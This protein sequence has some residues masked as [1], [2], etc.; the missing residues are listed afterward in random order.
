[1]HVES[2][3]RD[4]LK[5]KSLRLNRWKT[6]NLIRQIRANE[7]VE[8]LKRINSRMAIIALSVAVLAFSFATQV[9]QCRAYSETRSYTVDQTKVSGLYGLVVGFLGGLTGLSSLW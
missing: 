4:G 6:L 8:A 5:R 9:V 1:V 3:D 7:K 2:R